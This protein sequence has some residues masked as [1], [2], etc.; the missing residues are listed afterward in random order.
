[1]GIGQT[2]LEDH[3]ADLEKMKDGSTVV[4]SSFL[5]DYERDMEKLLDGSTVISVDD[6]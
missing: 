6:D 3:L 1:M 4:G 2:M 5:E